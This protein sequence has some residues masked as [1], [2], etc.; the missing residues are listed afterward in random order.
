LLAGF[1]FIILSTA[2]IIPNYLQTV[3]NYRELQVG[4]VLLWIALPQIVIVLPLGALLRRVDARWVLAFGAALIGVACLMATDLTS[5]WATV[6]FLPSQIL[7]ALGQSFALTALIVLI[8]RSINPSDA[9]TI[10]CLIQI[11]RLF[12]GEVGTAFMQTFVRMR[13]QLHSNLVGLHVDGIAG[14]T[15]DRL[16]AYQAAVGSRTADLGEAAARA[17]RL[18]STTVA[19]QASVLS[20]IDGFLAAA[21]GAFLCLLLVAIMR[22]PPPSAF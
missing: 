10:G 22:R 16:S 13:E 19:Q 15:V 1:R 5:Q 4:A 14:A 3:Q 8:V 18:L 9:L 7:Q 21:I 6:D 2:Y 12:G 17:A 11:S 20:F